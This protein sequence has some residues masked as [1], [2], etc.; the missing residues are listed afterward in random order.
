[1]VAIS[2]HTCA[3]L[4][5]MQ[6][7][8]CWQRVSNIAFEDSNPRTEPWFHEVRVTS[9]ASTGQCRHD[10]YFAK[11]Q[12]TEL[13]CSYSVSVTVDWN[14][15][16]NSPP[17]GRHCVVSIGGDTVD[18]PDCP[19][20]VWNFSGTN[21]A[22]GQSDLTVT[23]SCLQPDPNPPHKDIACPG[24][25][26][27][28]AYPIHSL[29]LGNRQNTSLLTLVRTSQ[30]PPT[31][32]G[33]GFP[34][35]FDQNQGSPTVT[36]YPT[37]GL[38]GSLYPGQR[39]VLR[40][41]HCKNN[42][43]SDNCDID[44]S[45]PGTSQ[46]IDCE[47]GAATGGQGHDFVMFANGCRP[48]YGPNSF[49]DPDWFPCPDKLEMTTDARYVPNGMGKAWR[50][51]VKAPGFSPNVIA[52][53]IAAAIGN[54]SNL[55]PNSCQQYT[56]T[57]YNFYDPARPRE[58]A[59]HGGK[60]SERVVFLF[61]VPYGAYKGTGS[62][63]TMPILTF[64]GFYITGWEGKGS[65]A[66]QNP[67]QSPDPDGT[68]PA[69]PDENTNGGDVVGYFV[70]YTIPNAPGDPNQHCVIGQLQPCVPVLVR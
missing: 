58:W 2:S 36:I 67:C 37:V 41:P 13:S 25:G 14:G 45:S 47:P 17:A 15:L 59:L 26:L 1:V 62:Q 23:Y 53:G 32:S 19:N 33:I 7:T 16:Q 30:N 55:Q 49:T 21:S 54:C 51:V 43:N 46:S 12:P 44:T 60:P 70:D 4:A 5:A 20:G 66:N 22:L 63:D 69:S 38:E 56:C 31:T 8:D 10:A 61:I 18:R 6:Y 40:A 35:D 39:R 27:N 3:Q 28:T 64:A 9:S 11:L 34:I 24:T 50:C 48:W 52:D 68:G 65:G 57:N 29:F 42:T